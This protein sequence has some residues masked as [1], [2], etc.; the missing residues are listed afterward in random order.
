MR[1][2]AATTDVDMRIPLLGRIAEMRHLLIRSLI[3]LMLIFVVTG[4]AVNERLPA[5][6]LSAEAQ[7]DILGIPDARFYAG[8]VQKLEH[9]TRKIVARRKQH[10]GAIEAENYLAISGGADDGAFGAG[11]LLGWSAR[12]DRPRFDIVTGVSTGALSAPFAFLGK[13]YDDDLKSIYTTVTANQ[14]F[15]MRP[16][17]YAALMSDAL[18][19]TTPLRQL[20]SHYLDAKMMRRLGEEFDKGRILLISTTN[21]DQSQPVIW[22]IGAIAKSNNPLARELIIDVLM[23]SAAVPGVF[24]P[25]M[26]S[27]MV[28][29]QPHQEMHVDG[30]TIAQTFLYPPS[31]NLKRLHAA[32]GVQRQ[33][34]AYVIRNGRLSPPESTVKQSTLPITVKTFETMIATAGVSDSYRIYLATKRDG[35][36]FNFAHIGDDFTVPY[37]GP[38]VPEYMQKLFNYGY[39]QSIKGNLWLNKPPYFAE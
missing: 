19:D 27:V 35:I 12:G 23:A 4:C 20:I 18:A 36:A 11:L 7:V 26:L 22:N 24:P 31:L 25:V 30:G 17:I 9:Y 6:P 13:D 21:L 5:V 16:L 34:T 33:R 14:I 2:V 28:N 15:K 1:S 29:G 10:F 39:Q 32:E 37:P 3:A 38:F 8:D